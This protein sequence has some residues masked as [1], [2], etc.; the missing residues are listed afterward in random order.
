MKGVTIL[1]V[2]CPCALVLA[3]PTAIMAAIGQ[4]TKKGVIIKSGEA[5]EKMGKVNTITFDKTGT[6]TY[7]K[8]E[9]S[10]IT[11]LDPELERDTFISIAAGAEKR[12]EHPLA[13]SL[14]SYA[15]KAGIE[16]AA[17][18]AFS[19]ASGKGI[20]A[21]AC[22][23]KILCGNRK[24]MEENGISLQKAE[25][26]IAMLGNDGKAM[27]LIAID[28]VLAGIIG[29]SDRLREESRTMI[30]QLSSIGMKSVLLTGDNRKAADYMA[31]RI[32]LSEVYPDLL[33]SQKASA[34]KAMQ[35][36][37]RIVAM[38]GDGVND[39]PALKTADVGIAMGAIGSDIAIEAAD[40]A[41]MGDDISKIPY[42]KRLSDATVK[43]IR[44]SITLSLIINLIAI[45]LSILGI[46]T[47]TTGALWH[48]AGSVLVI[49]IAALLYDRKF[50]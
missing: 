30:E 37:G 21:E 16:P 49:L 44:L 1:V 2:F 29:F 17:V 15:E 8:P 9:V 18:T 27:I 6:L 4:A 20:L 45:I 35:Q 11:V 13:K 26:T 46:M 3:T 39:A 14:V 24:L 36:E 5:L 23:R 7:G 33:P 47:P 22:G 41:L 40:I 38:I 42:L 31:K 43:T 10:D 12:S 19:M 28:N 32:G 50:E 34:V 48:N 25:N